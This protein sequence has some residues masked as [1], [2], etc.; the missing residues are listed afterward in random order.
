MRKI[1]IKKHTI[2]VAVAAAFAA[3]P[4]AA[5]AEINTDSKINIITNYRTL[6]ALSWDTQNWP[7]KINHDQLGL[8]TLMRGDL[9]YGPRGSGEFSFN[10]PD[11]LPEQFLEGGLAESWEQHPDRLVFNLREGVEW[12]EVPGVMERRPLTASDVVN[13][14]ET[15]K[16]T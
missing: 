5:S 9:S 3:G 6:D 7:W 13:H 11:H 1:G 10:Y 14:F 8:E 2:A 12:W 15:M 4:M 16:G